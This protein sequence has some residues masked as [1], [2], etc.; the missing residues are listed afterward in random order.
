MG[1]ASG[2]GVTS[3]EEA[4]IQ[5]WYY[6]NK[7]LPELKNGENS[8]FQDPSTNM[9]YLKLGNGTIRIQGN[10]ED[11]ILLKILETVHRGD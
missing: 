11:P 5:L 6:P 7:L 3:F 8:F 1:F 4:P 2:T 10:M 9:T